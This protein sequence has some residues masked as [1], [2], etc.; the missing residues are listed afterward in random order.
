[1]LSW[2]TEQTPYCL[3]KVA[4]VPQM[5]LQT[6]HLK[7]QCSITL[8]EDLELGHSAPNVIICHGLYRT[9]TSSSSSSECQETPG[10]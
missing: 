8:F 4:D 6:S 7:S 3:H 1:M 2:R 10:S 9:G 5:L